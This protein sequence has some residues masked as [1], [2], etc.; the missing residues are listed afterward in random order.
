MSVLA[1]ALLVLVGSVVGIVALTWGMAALAEPGAL[2]VEAE[3]DGIDLLY[4]A[5]AAVVAGA[6]GM[7]LKRPQD[8]LADRRAAQDGSQGVSE[9]SVDAGARALDELKQHEDHCAERYRKVHER[10]DDVEKRLAAVQSDVS[11]I[12]GLMEGQQRGQQS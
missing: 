7:F 5:L 12:R 2:V 8:M 11:Y 1:K 10:I 9:G 6:G 4:A 3:K